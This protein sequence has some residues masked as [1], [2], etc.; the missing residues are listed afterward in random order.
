MDVGGFEVLADFGGGLVD[1]AVEGGAAARLD[2]ENPGFG[3]GEVADVL[4][5][6]DGFDFTVEGDERKDIAGTEAAE[7]FD[8]GLA[9]VF[10]FLTRH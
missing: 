7:S 6:N 2:G 9:G 5:G 10:D 3:V 1:A 4:G 8:G